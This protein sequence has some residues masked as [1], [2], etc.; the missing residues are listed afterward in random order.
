MS[1]RCLLCPLLPQTGARLC[2][3]HV[4]ALTDMLDPANTGRSADDVAASIPR[5]WAK[6]DPTPGG[7]GGTD[8]RRPP[9]FHSAPAA[10]LHAV[11]MRDDRGRNNPQVWYDPHPSGRGDDLTRP[12][13]E[14]ANPPRPVRLAV[15]SLFDALVEELAPIGPRLRNGRWCDS[16]VT[17]MASALVS[18]LPEILAYHHVDEVFLDLLDL[19]DQLRRAVGDAPLKPEGRCIE[20]VT[21]RNTTV[22][23]EC[24][25]PLTL[26]PPTPDEPEPPNETE[27]QARRRKARERAKEVARCH[28][29]HRRYSWLDLIRIQHISRPDAETV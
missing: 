7:G 22:L 19:S 21:D 12:H 16:D 18:W 2:W 14:E 28:R 13:I 1:D 3:K 17:T 25:W 6:L 27:D 15:E 10:S 26:L 20:M 23:R 11:A 5:L 9:G 29:C 4:D 24:G 8:E